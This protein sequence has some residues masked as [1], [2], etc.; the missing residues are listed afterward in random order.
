MRR[1]D[2]VDIEIG[3]DQ[4]AAADALHVAGVIDHAQ[5]VEHLADDLGRAGV[6]AAGAE[7]GDGPIKYA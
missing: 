6:Q 7:A 1:G 4:A 5:L 3:H 2:G